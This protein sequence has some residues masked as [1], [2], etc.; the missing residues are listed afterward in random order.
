MGIADGV[1][2]SAN[3]TIFH[4]INLVVIGS[5]IVILLLLNIHGVGILRNV[6]LVLDHVSYRLFMVVYLSKGVGI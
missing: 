6:L 5:R 4:A 2:V 1:E 3:G